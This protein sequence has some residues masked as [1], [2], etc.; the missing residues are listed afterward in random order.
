MT[1]LP[2]GRTEAGRF[3]PGHSGNPA[4][5]R[6]EEFSFNGILR[7]A[8][9]E[10]NKAGKTVGERIVARYIK[11][12]LAGNQPA[13]EALMARIDGK[14]AQSLTLKGDSDAPLHVR[15]SAR[16]EQPPKEPM[17]SATLTF[18]P[19][20]KLE[21]Q[22]TVEGEAVVEVNPGPS[23]DDTWAESWIPPEQRS[24]LGNT[25]HNEPDS[26]EEG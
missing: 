7:S 15:H 18:E 13:I 22:D 23:T 25:D 24:P 20:P 12:G 5:R 4:G 9:A 8:L 16:L 14:P 6:S 2:A 11:L 17:Q 10:R 26:P 3:A 19:A 1:D 21:A